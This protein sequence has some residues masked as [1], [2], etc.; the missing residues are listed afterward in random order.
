VFYGHERVALA[1]C[2]TALDELPQLWNIFIV[3]M[4]L[5][6]PRARRSGEIKVR[7]DGRFE[8]LEDMPGFE[9]R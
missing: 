3:E 1:G 8:Q 4:S 2:A 7:G 6:V 9:A 5:V